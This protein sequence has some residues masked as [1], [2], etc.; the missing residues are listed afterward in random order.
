VI[1]FSFIDVEVSGFDMV[2]VSS[3][4]ELVCK[5]EMKEV[6]DINYIFCNDEYL[7]EINRSYLDHDY[8]T[9]VITF[10][11][12]EGPCLSGDIFVSIDRVMENAKDFNVSFLNELCRV[13]VHGILHLAGYKD[14]LKDDEQL[15]RSKE[16]Y[17]LLN[18]VPR[19]TF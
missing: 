8:Y 2:N 12:S 5:E 15:M 19:E 16:D 18:Y 10:D 14:K 17:Y 13:V 3:W 6:G 11:Y 1:A 7:L 9:D 4:L